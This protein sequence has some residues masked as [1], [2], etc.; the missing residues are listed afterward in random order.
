MLKE[1]HY[2]NEEGKTVF[3]E[4]FHLK[5]GYCCGSGC[6]HCPFPKYLARPTDG[7]VWVLNE[8][9]S[10]YSNLDFKTNYPEH[11]QYKHSLILLKNIGFYA[12]TEDDFADL[13]KKGEVYMDYLKW[14]GRPDGHGGC[15][16]GTMEE[17]LKLKK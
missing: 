3:T 5:R 13:K 10:T 7:E 8:D 17:F 1:D 16:G 14:S 12:V 2:I 9:R 11:I 4:E 6:L 15:K